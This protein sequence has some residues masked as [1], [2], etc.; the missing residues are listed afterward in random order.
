MNGTNRL[1]SLT[2]LLEPVKDHPRNRRAV[3]R[4]DRFGIEFLSLV[5]EES[6]RLQHIVTQMELHPYQM[7]AD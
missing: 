4:E 5:P 1:L 3:T 7:K 6:A 2:N